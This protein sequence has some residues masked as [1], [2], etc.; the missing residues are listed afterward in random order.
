MINLHYI[1]NGEKAIQFYFTCD[2]ESNVNELH[3]EI[4]NNAEKY[5]LLIDELRSVPKEFCWLLS[6]SKFMANHFI[7]VHVRPEYILEEHL[8]KEARKKEQ[9]QE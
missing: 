3:S 8:E 5:T 9:E 7:A 4:V 2:P 1:D 6:H